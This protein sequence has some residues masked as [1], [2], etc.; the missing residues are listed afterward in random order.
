MLAT[1]VY[2]MRYIF[3]DRFLKKFMKVRSVNNTI[4]NNSL[5]EGRDIGQSQASVLK[6]SKNNRQ[7]S[8][9]G[10]DLTTSLIDFWA[11][12][13]R[14]GMAASFTVQDMLGTNF[15]RTFAAL[16][17]NKD[18]TGKNNYK[19]AVEVAIREFTTGPSM[20]IIPA[21]VLAGAS[22][23]SGEANKVPVDNI[24]IF[25]D[26]MKGSINTLGDNKFKDID[27][28]SLSKDELQ[29]A[30]IEIK[31]TFY[32]DVFQNI[33]SQFEGASDINI[34]EYV[35]LM[36]KA[37]DQATPK[38]NFFMSMFNKKITKD[39]VQVDAKDEIL[40]QLS[41]KFVADKKSHTQGWG[42]FL[43]AKIIPGSKP[44]KISDIVDDMK[45][46]SNDFAKQYLSAQG[47]NV[48]S[49]SKMLVEKFVDNFR[50]A[51]IGSRFIT[52]VMMVV[53]TGLFMS[54]IPKL[55]TR[56]KTNPE[57][58]AI[59]AQVNKQRQGAANNENK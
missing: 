39:G 27:F 52:N 59:Y 30:N 45:N 4:I 5:T 23:Y 54:I 32:K 25:S 15:P 47:K 6:N 34:D 7:I 37:E 21:L 12:I 35:D 17:R 2:L 46:Y 8:F 13:A 40:S 14:G 33:F 38:R 51:R 55:Y 41:T 1:Y 29:N 43:T 10:A 19:A 48:Q 11:A 16:D 24:A 20:F 53:A 49:N 26:I 22:H 44:L 42:D 28:K 36:L 18:I 9:K 56:N 58:D 31:K 3:C 50:D 57:T